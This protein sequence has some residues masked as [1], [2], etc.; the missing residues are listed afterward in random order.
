MW[1]H[2]KK[3]ADGRDDTVM[4]L[5]KRALLWMDVTGAS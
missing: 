4:K 1:Q 3:G 5:D 2:I